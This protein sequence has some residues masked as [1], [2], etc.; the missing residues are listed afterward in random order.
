MLALSVAV[1]LLIALAG[2]L[3]PR[4]VKPLVFGCMLPMM[5]FLAFPGPIPVSGGLLGFICQ[6]FT[7][8]R[9]RPSAF[10]AQLV[11]LTGVLIMALIGY[12][13][14]AIGLASS[15]FNGRFLAMPNTS[16]FRLDLAQP[17]GLVAAHFN[18]LMYLLVG[19]FAAMCIAARFRRTPPAEV[20]SVLDKPSGSL[21][22]ATA[23]PI[24]KPSSMSG[25]GRGR[26]TRR[27]RAS[28]VSREAIRSRR[29]WGPW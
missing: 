12:D 14:F 18:Q 27:S 5:D 13:L 23:C 29:R 16:L 6:I 26:L 1:C 8:V 22:D 9:P 10:L 25:L 28:T 4:G 20:I 15:V 2:I 11:S 7:T 24:L 3:S 17:V 21:S 19:G